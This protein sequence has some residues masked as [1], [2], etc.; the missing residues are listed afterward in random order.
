MI[1]TAAVCAALYCAWVSKGIE[2]KPLLWTVGL[3]AIS[4]PL[5]WLSRYLKSPQAVIVK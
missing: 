1:T 4:A 5:Y 3:G 2:I